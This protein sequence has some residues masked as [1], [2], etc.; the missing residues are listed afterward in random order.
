[1]SNLLF[2]SGEY[3]YLKFLICTGLSIIGYKV[4]YSN[5]IVFEQ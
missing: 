3:I 5:I 4:E 1:M 2:F